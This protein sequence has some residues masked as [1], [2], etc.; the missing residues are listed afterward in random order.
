MTTFT[1][2]P[3]TLQELS[4][5][6]SGIDRLRDAEHARR[7]DRVRGLLGGSDLEGEITHFCSNARRY[8]DQILAE[9]LD[10]TQKAAPG[11]LDLPA[12]LP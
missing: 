4:S 3:A 12:R 5:T 2:G 6:L 1:V 8:S 11:I 9:L 7:G 10:R